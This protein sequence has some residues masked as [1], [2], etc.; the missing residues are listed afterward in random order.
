MKIS[1]DRLAICYYG[2]DGTATT[3]ETREV[4]VVVGAGN[5]EGTFTTDHNCSGTQFPIAG[6]TDITLTGENT[7]VIENAFNLVGGQ[8]DLVV[9][10]SNVTVPTQEQALA[11]GIAT[12]T[13][14]GSGTMNSTATSFVIDYNYDNAAPLIGGQGSCTVT[15][16]RQ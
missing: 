8:I 15:Y 14:D 4:N 1:T 12:V 10:G 5:Y 13:L 6:E 9:D 7:L 11:G 3:T 2:F 16:T